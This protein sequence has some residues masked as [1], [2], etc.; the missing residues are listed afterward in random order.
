MRVYAIKIFFPIDTEM[1]LSPVRAEWADGESAE[2]R[3]FCGKAFQPICLSLCGSENRG[4]MQAL[5]RVESPAG[6][7]TF[8][9]ADVNRRCPIYVR[10]S[11]FLVTEESDRRAYGQITDELLSR[12][13]QSETEC[14]A[15]TEQT[16]FVSAAKATE[17]VNHSCPTWLGVPGDMRV[18]E[19]GFRGYP[20]EERQHMELYDYIQPRCNWDKFDYPQYGIDRMLYRYMVGRGMGCTSRIVRR[21]ENGYLPILHASVFDGDLEYRLISFV[22]FADGKSIADAEGTD[23]LVADGHSAGHTFTEQQQAEYEARS[24]R[25]AVDFPVLRMRITVMNRASCAKLAFVRLPHVNTFVMAEREDVKDQHYDGEAGIGSVGDLVYL[26]ASLD[27]HPCEALETA[28]IVFPDVPVTYELV[29]FHGLVD[30]KIAQG[31]QP[32]DFSVEL[33]KVKADWKKL[34][35]EQAEIRVPE[36]RI[37]EMWRAGYWHV[38]QNTFAQRGSDVAAATVGVYSPIGSESAT[39]IEFL[40]SSRNAE[41]ARKSVNYFFAKQHS[42]GFIQNQTRY[43]LETGGALCIAGSCFRYTDDR[44]RLKKIEEPLLRACDYLL[45]W[46][47]RNSVEEGSFG[48]GMID[49]QVADPVDNYRLFSLNAGAYAGL[50]E[51]A[52]LMSVLKNP[53]AHELEVAAE[54]LRKNILVAL[55]LRLGTAVLTPVGDGGWLPLLPPWAETDSAVCLHT[56]DNVCTTHASCVLKDSLLSVASLIRCGVLRHDDPLADLIVQTQSDLFTEH[57]T[58]FSQPYYNA[59]PWALLRRG[60]INA[61]L[62]EFY[63][64]MSALADRETY[65]FWE[66]YFL[67][68]PHKIA[69]ET[70]FLMRLRELLYYEDLKERTLHLMRAVPEKWKNAR[71]NTVAVRNAGCE[72]GKIS[73]SFEQSEGGYT[74]K[75]D[76][77]WNENREVEVLVYPPIRRDERLVACAGWDIENGVLKRAVESGGSEFF[78]E[79]DRR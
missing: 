64:A 36:R 72:F 50:A 38:L 66:H 30:K 74:L 3:R 49:G 16:N 40:N 4:S 70:Q 73:F 8:K 9:L 52:E 35:A 29:L 51:A 34:C 11:G 39:A 45:G 76:C 60:Q 69:E 46:I 28:P 13:C 41:L 18:F 56:Q 5:L 26:R 53:R 71:N 65:S 77:E 61:Y 42:D 62:D 78:V 37:G 57:N 17:K 48:F 10:Q 22:G 63:H 33:K 15:C 25:D 6:S 79:V 44:D 21:L 58:A 20:I 67:A 27:G 75:L 19:L 43:M 12:N 7:Y 32:E 14:A 24:K 1:L 55:R 59:I 68:T 54:T 47:E 23:Y 2:P 31:C